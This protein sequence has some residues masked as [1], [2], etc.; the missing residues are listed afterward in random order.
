MSLLAIPVFCVWLEVVQRWQLQLVLMNGV[1]ACA[2][3]PWQ[4]ALRVVPSTEDYR[5]LRVAAA[6]CS[7]FTFADKRKVRAVAARTRSE[8]FLLGSVAK[9]KPGHKHTH[10]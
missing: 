1:R 10:H 8:R 9:Q 2:V 3:L 4:Q 5:D 7:G 6:H